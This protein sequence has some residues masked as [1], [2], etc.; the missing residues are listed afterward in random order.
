MGDVGD[1]AVNIWA[2]IGTEVKVGAR[3]WGQGTSIRIRLNVL[4][5]DEAI[6]PEEEAHNC[7]ENSEQEQID[8]EGQ[9]LP[10]C[11]PT[12]KPPPPIAG[13]RAQLLHASRECVHVIYIDLSRLSGIAVDEVL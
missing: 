6:V 5:A 3:S 13:V 8:Q 9:S 2:T 12:M 7:H 4:V 11:S 10:D 1:S